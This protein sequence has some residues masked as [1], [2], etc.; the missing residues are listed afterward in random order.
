MVNGWKSKDYEY[1]FIEIP[2]IP[3]KHG[4]PM[5]WRK[6]PKLCLFAY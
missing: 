3:G 4:E 6:I 2:T 5:I 1:E